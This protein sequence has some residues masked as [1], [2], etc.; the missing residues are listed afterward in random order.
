MDKVQHEIDE[1]MRKHDARYETWISTHRTGTENRW[2][3]GYYMAF[4]AILLGM[5]CMA[6]VIGINENPMY[7]MLM[8][9]AALL[10]P[11]VP[12]IFAKV[13][14]LCYRGA[15]SEE[16]KE[17]YDQIRKELQNIRGKRTPIVLVNGTRQYFRPKV[18][19]RADKNGYA[20][21][22]VIITPLENT[23]FMTSIYGQEKP[24]SKKCL[25]FSIPVR[26]EAD[27]EKWQ[28]FSAFDKIELPY[29]RIQL[30]PNIVV[31][32]WSYLVP[33]NVPSEE[34][35][36]AFEKVC[37]MVLY[38]IVKEKLKNGLKEPIT[39]DGCI[40]EEDLAPYFGRH[41][42]N[43]RTELT[44]IQRAAEKVEDLIAIKEGQHIPGINADH[45]NPLA[46]TVAREC[47]EY[48]TNI[49]DINREQA[50]NATGVEEPI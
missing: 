31:N 38:D 32:R 28:K 44:E 39:E 7:V 8:V 49:V 17:F 33:Y 9:P 42:T 34:I 4:G 24:A 11:C 48:G 25:T 21:A 14:G 27:I 16:W 37:R 20:F 43:A 35:Q 19:L 23:E 47:L 18:T 30:F 3:A 10:Y 45:E 22:D 40:T 29:I 36:G 46:P 2:A 1:L 15:P 5:A 13:E 12:D 26:E 41:S 50:D 6:P